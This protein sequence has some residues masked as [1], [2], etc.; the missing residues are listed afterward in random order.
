MNQDDKQY[1]VV[2]SLSWTCGRRILH[3]DVT[4]DNGCRQRNSRKQSLFDLIRSR[5]RRQCSW[6]DRP[7]SQ[8]ALALPFARSIGIYRDKVVLHSQNQHNHVLCFSASQEPVNPITTPNT[9]KAKAKATSL[10]SST[11]LK[12]PFFLMTFWYMR[13]GK[14]KT[15]AVANVP[16]PTALIR[17]R[18]ETKQAMSVMSPSRPTVT[19]RINAPVRLIIGTLKIFKTPSRIPMNANG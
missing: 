5:F 11:V 8:P 9:I 6:L 19:N 15:I 3:C 16:H 18:S 7:R 17:P 14:T 2:S 4:K 13:A 12:A 10:R 1:C